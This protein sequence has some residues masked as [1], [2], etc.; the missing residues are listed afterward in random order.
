MKQFGKTGT[1]F[2]MRKLFDVEAER[3]KRGNE[4]ELLI[5]EYNYII[6]VIYVY[7]NYYLFPYYVSG[8]IY[9]T[10]LIKPHSGDLGGIEKLKEDI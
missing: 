2:L 7:K 8:I 6:T 3:S 1:R 5:F 9:K 10:M 4:E